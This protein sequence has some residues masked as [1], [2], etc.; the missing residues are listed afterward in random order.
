MFNRQVLMKLGLSSLAIAILSMSLPARAEIVEANQHR[1]SSRSSY[2]RQR[3][4]YNQE[5]LRLDELI[6]QQEQQRREN[7]RRQQQE[8]RLRE[9]QPAENFRRQ[10][11]EYRQRQEELRIEQQQRW[12]DITRQQYNLPYEGRQPLLFVPR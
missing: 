12:D 2:Q 11:E 9:A 4:L 5:R 7:W 1:Q 3:W 8:Y 6:R 10:Q